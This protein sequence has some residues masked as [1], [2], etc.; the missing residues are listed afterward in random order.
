MNALDNMGEYE[1]HTVLGGV[2]GYGWKTDVV[3]AR[4]HVNR[5]CQAGGVPLME[6]GTAGYLGQVSTILRVSCKS[7][8]ELQS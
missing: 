7:R 4:R 2:G 8:L 5:L 3:D 1:P 6:S